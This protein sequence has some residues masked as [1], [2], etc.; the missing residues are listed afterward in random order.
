MKR[1]YSGSDVNYS[2]VEGSQPLKSGLLESRLGI[3][4]DGILLSHQRYLF[5]EMVPIP[6]KQKNCINQRA[7]VQEPEE[8]KQRKANNFF[9]YNKIITFKYSKH[10]NNSKV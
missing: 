8:T 2:N 1:P 10:P 3:I 9:T 7:L 5:Q 6:E 4:P